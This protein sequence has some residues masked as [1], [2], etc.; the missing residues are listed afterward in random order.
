VQGGRLQLHHQ[1]GDHW[2]MLREPAVR[3]LAEQL[4]ADLDKAAIEDSA[5][6]AACA[7]TQTKA[8]PHAHAAATIKVNT[9][10]NS[11][12]SA[13]APSSLVVIQSGAAGAT[14]VFAVPGAGANVTCFVP[15]ALALGSDVPLYGLQPQG[16]DGAHAPIDTVQAA[17]SVY[18]DTIE[19][20]VP[21]GPLVLVGHSFGGWVAFDTARQ[22]RVRGVQ[23]KALVLLDSAVPN[24]LGPRG[25][26]LDRLD[27]LMDLQRLLAQQADRPLGLHRDQL[28]AM[29]ETEQAGALHQAMVNVGLLNAHSRAESVLGLVRVFHC[30]LNTPYVP[31]QALDVPTWVVRAQDAH[32]QRNAATPPQS[33][34]SGAQ[35]DRAAGWHALAPVSWSGVVPGNHMSMLQRPHVNAVAEMM[36]A[37]MGPTG[38]AA[39]AAPAGRARPSQEALL[40][41]TSPHGRSA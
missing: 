26:T 2:S 3:Q 10:A 16:L 37:L 31:A 7:P 23:V 39:R 38:Q 27:A 25:R 40:R 9:Q 19:A 13:Q 15:L 14:P 30:N 28:A 4:N 5:G 36:L 1:T 11:Q 18:A 41:S 22:L 35:A 8:Q 24:A 34:R 21:S 6:T 33:H 32:V 17:A 29:S 12:A 20:Q